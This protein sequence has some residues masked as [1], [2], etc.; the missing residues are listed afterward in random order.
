MKDNGPWERG[1]KEGPSSALAYYLEVIFRPRCREGEPKQSPGVTLTW[2]DELI[3]WG[4]QRGWSSQ[5]SALERRGWHRKRTVR[6]I[7]GGSLTILPSLQLRTNQHMNVRKP[8]EARGES[9]F[10]TEGNNIWA[11]HRTRNNPCSQKHISYFTRK[12]R[13]YSEKF[14][15]SRRKI[16][17]RINAL[18]V[19]P[20]KLKN[21]IKKDQ[22]IAK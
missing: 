19:W 6:S 11:S 1:N 15:L 16:S 8:A 7:D 22:T 2:R 5:C 10:R 9:P 17:P 3:V 13:E 12:W 14:Y 20:K 4:G 21:K 18:L